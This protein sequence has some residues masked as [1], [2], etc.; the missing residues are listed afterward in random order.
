MER[1][2][3]APM[4]SMTDPLMTAGGMGASAALRVVSIVA[5]L[6]VD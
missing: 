2:A 5:M 4:R 6:A 3:T 1:A